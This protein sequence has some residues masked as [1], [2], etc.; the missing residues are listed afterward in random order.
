VT[1]DPRV[2]FARGLE[3][4]YTVERELG[5]GGM[6]TVYLAQDLKHKRPVALKVLHAE[7]AHALGPARF[8]REIETAARLQHPHILTV[9]DS[10]ETQGQL[11]F[12]MPYVEG[13]SL[14]DRLAREKQ[15]PVAD[16][17]RI[18][19]EA[20]RALDYAHRHGVL[21]RD[22]KP[23]NIL[24]AEDGT[25]LVADFGI[26][27][28]LGAGG[29]E[30][31]TATGVA[32][33]TPAYMSPE[34]GS[35]ERTLDARTDVYALGCVLYEMLAG[36]APWTGPTAQA[37]IARRFSEP[38]PSV[39]RVRPTVPA[40]VD[41]AIQRALAPVPADRFPTARSFADALAAAPTSA[42]PVPTDPAAAAAT[43]LARRRRVSPAL[44]MLLI[45]LLIGG[46]ALFA[47]RRRESSAAA[48]AAARAAS[49]ETRA[50]RVAVLPFDNLGDSA[51]AYFSDG[52]TDAIRGK[53]AAI[54]GLA[55]IAR[56]SSEQYRGTTKPPEQIAEELGVDYLLTGT[57]R[58]A[59][60]ATGSDGSSGGSGG[61]DGTSRVQVSPELVELGDGTAKTRWGEPFDAPLSDVFQVQGD[62]AARVTQALRLA[63]PGAEQ[64][65]LVKSPTTN[66]EAYDAFL[67][68][69]A[70]GSAGGAPAAL[71]RALAH[72]E[73]AVALD[74]TMVEGWAGIAR[75][76]SGLYTVSTPT[77]ALAE[78]ARR[79]AE[80][81]VA[82]EPDGVAAQRALGIYYLAVKRDNARALAALE[83]AYRR[84]P[85][86]VTVLSSLAALQGALGRWE[87]ALRTAQAAFVL[88]PRSPRSAS[89]VATA[90][91]YLRRLPE[92]R[93]AAERTL[94]LAP[95]SPFAIQGRVMVAL[96]A[97]D[98]ADAR[99]VLAAAAADVP[100]A[101]L[102]AH[103]ALFCDLFWVLDDAGQRLALALGPEAY[104]GDRAAWSLVRA[105]L[106][107]RRG[108]T[109]QARV[110]AD[111][112]ARVLAAH[113]RDAPDDPQ[114]PVLRGLAL[115][116]LG[117]RAEA[118]AEAERGLALARATPD[119]TQIP[120][121][122]HQ[123]VRIHLLLGEP[124][125][126]LDG[127]EALLKQPYW[128]TPAWLGID[129]EFAP[130][131]GN[132][133]FERL[134]AAGP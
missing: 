63:L 76:A 101:E 112:A 84:A 59:K 58:W 71:R 30:K 53:L 43:P 55:V 11:W 49:V 106:H 66:P 72:Y 102:A 14:R 132:P 2:A 21:H 25:T 93:V 70:A 24:L 109:A 82:L 40:A 114:R 48:A 62:I 122:E 130:L 12:T 19:S 81:A 67:R 100:A 125:R 134:I 127:L 80:R 69:E 119:A 22:I 54:S 89:G 117:R 36:E 56:A 33:G 87:E 47:W 104:D 51:D 105:Q 16:A 108:D 99:R 1:D 3:D 91:L 42:T 38:A 97:G 88:D 4:R 27:R 110:W 131:R 128:L 118:L 77:P 17:L 50:V 64:A 83:A 28:A 20:A 95:G 85:G 133:R 86:D 35:G 94:A 103:M 45:G 7:L 113:I 13:E 126:A 34:Q 6:A 121:Y 8:E 29:A 90:S 98:L 26:A 15:L 65:R 123:V 9:H 124:E 68:A 44:A 115:A 107:Y 129:P 73:R 78:R 37:I 39:R 41:A 23:E 120:Y 32:I 57:V 92:A 18:A 5:R 60:P 10:G 79:A 96:A 52:V 61:T 111:T 75:N 31:L 74:S 116:F 46:G